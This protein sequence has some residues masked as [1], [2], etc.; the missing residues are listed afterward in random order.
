MAGNIVAPPTTT[1]E[2]CADADDAEKCIE[3]AATLA[4][5]AE[6]DADAEEEDD[7]TLLALGCDAKRGNA[8]GRPTVDVGIDRSLCCIF[9]KP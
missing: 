8:F 9:T 3:A 5:A 4:A 7:I 1:P 2:P 6:A